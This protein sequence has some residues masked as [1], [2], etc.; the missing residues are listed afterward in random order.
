MVKSRYTY[1]R[2]EV[3]R[4][5]VEESSTMTM[6]GRMKREGITWVGGGAITN[7][8]AN[9]ASLTRR[10]RGEREGNR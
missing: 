10:G 5:G 6:D 2:T 1:I 4:C 7:G 9:K 3:V 8:R